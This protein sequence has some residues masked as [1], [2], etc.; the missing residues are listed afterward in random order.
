MSIYLDYAASAPVRPAARAAYEAALASPGNPSSIHRDGQHAKRI[1]D[2][3]S[4]ALGAAVGADPIEV[5]WTSGGTE[6]VN[7]GITGLFRAR[8]HQDARRNRIVVA[9][10]EH[11]A[12]MDTVESLATHEGAVIDWVPVNAEG[13]INLGALAVALREHPD[14]I[15]LVTC[16]WANNEVGTRQPIRDISLLCAET[17]VPLHVDAVAALGHDD[18][19]VAGIRRESGATGATGLVALSLAGHKIGSVPGVGALILVREANAEAIIHGGGQQRGIRSGTLNAP[20]IASMAAALEDAQDNMTQK[21]L[22]LAELRDYAFA[23]IQKA[24]PEAVARGCRD[25]R[26]ANNVHFTFPGCQSDSLLYGLDQAGIS[27]SAGS[28]CQAGVA[29][30]S[31]VLLAMGLGE[32]DAQS[33][34]R[35]TIGPETTQAD[36][37]A[38]IAALP[39]AYAAA[40][41]AG[42]TA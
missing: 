35:I 16:L 3:A 26:L 38:F 14:E 7:L 36:V 34:L 1:V 6:S 5:V 37:D 2:T 29:R 13:R 10:A 41:K 18:I 8:H 11:H 23:G 33:A 19:N 27:V 39:A 28:A 25:D 21:Q 20:A 42:F 31:H 4:V 15:A 32:K 40:L 12:T 22:Q 17:G 24:I 30:P 9:E